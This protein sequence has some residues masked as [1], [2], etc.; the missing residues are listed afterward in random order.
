MKA[1]PV[2]SCP[3]R[4][5]HLL[6]ARQAAKNR[7]SARITR[8]RIET[9]TKSLARQLDHTCQVLRELDY[10]DDNFQ[11]RDAGIMLQSVYNERD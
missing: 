7:E 10:V 11:L 4:D 5:K 9:R 2:Y 8:Q 6:K 3:E 1:H